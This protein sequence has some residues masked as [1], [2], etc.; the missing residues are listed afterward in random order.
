MNNLLKNNLFFVFLSGL[1]LNIPFFIHNFYG[2]LFVFFALIPLFYVLPKIEKERAYFYGLIFFGSWLI[3]TSIWYFK[4]FPFFIAIA[5][6]TF[7]TLMAVIFQLSSIFKNIYIKYLSFI[8]IWFL[9][10][11]LRYNLPITQDW[12]IPDLYYT[13]SFHPF[14]LQIIKYLSI[15]SLILLVLF[16]N[17]FLGFLLF[18]KKYKYFFSGILFLFLFVFFGNYYFINSIKVT[19][20]NFSLIALQNLTSGGI[21]VHANIKDVEYLVKKTENILNSRYFNNKN[22]FVLFPENKIS[23]DYYDLIKSSA[24]ENNINIIFNS[25]EKIDK[26]YL[27]SVVFVNNLGEISFINYKKHIAPGEDGFVSMDSDNSYLIDKIKLTSAVCYDLHYFDIGKRFKGKDLA[28]ISV[29]DAAFGYNMPYFH[30][31][32]IVFRAI[33]NNISILSSSTNAPT[34]FVDKNGIIK[35]EVLKPYSDSYIIYNF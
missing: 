2:Q 1:L 4:V 21:D 24:I 9:I 10:S 3:P 29:N 35:T 20:N 18:K 23:E 30:L 8:F 26:G 34:F 25:K 16:S 13:L 11:V 32:D 33:E 22:T 27:N 5:S 6:M 17:A 19:N 28:F 15:F 14:I 31:A 12:W 7:F